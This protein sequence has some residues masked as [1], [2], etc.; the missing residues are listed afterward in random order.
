MP[1]LKRRK[2]HHALLYYIMQY[3]TELI[4]SAIRRLKRESLL[5]EVIAYQ[6][7]RL[8]HIAKDGIALSNGSESKADNI[9]GH[10]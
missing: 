3:A 1:S 9:H 5:L 2:K 4:F 10:S 8:C 7:I 6:Q